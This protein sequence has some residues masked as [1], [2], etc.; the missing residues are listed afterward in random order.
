[1]NVIFYITEYIL[2]LVRIALYAEYVTATRN[3]QSLNTVYA[4]PA[5]AKHFNVPTFITRI[6]VALV[7]LVVRT[8]RLAS[9]P[10]TNIRRRLAII[11]K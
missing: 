6:I 11:A 1:M 7:Q 5:G 10:R 4:S 9:V 8:I 3:D 2:L